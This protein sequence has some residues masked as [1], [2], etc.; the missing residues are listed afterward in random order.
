MAKKRNG[1]PKGPQTVDLHIRVSPEIK[2]ELMAIADR[3]RRTL[4]AQTDLL[5]R[6]AIEADKKAA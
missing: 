1:R 2:V 4:N 3:E 6:R 5:L